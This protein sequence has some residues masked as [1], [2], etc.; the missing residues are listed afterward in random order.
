MQHIRD[1]KLKIIN[2]VIFYYY[3]FFIITKMIKRTQIKQILFS[4]KYNNMDVMLCGRLVTKRYAAKNTI[5]FLMLNDGTCFDDIQVV[6]NKSKIENFDELLSSK[7]GISSSFEIH[8]KVV[9]NERNKQFEIDCE[10]LRVLGY[11]GDDYPI[12]K[13]FHTMEYLRQNNDMRP[14]TKVI[15]SVMKVRNE[16]LYATH[17]YFQNNNFTC[18]STPIITTSDC[19]GAGEMFQVTT[20]PLDDK[21]NMDKCYK[22]GELEYENDFFGE[23]SYLTVSGQLNGEIYAC[24]MG[25]IYTFGPTF[26][27]ENSNTRRHLAEFWMIEPEMAYA[28]INR[29]MLVAEEY[30]K[31]CLN[32]VMENCEKELEYLDTYCSKH[33]DEKEDIPLLEKLNNIISNDFQKVT[34]TE[35]IEILEENNELFSEKVYWGIDLSSEHE[36]WLVEKYFKKPTIVIDYPKEIK[37]FYM[38]ENDDGKTVAA[39]DVLV[40]G[41]GE[42]IGGSQREERLDRLE[43]RLEENDL[44]KETYKF[45]LNLRKYG[46]VVHSGFGLGF[47]RLVLLC[48]GMKNIRDVIPFPR[49]PKH[50]SDI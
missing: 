28:D 27:A 30:V 49:W 39:M 17:K 29:N 48:T 34:Y 35:A 50:G 3:Y 36:R 8:G 37:S 41:I 7:C 26:R 19:E 31:Y 47:E 32:H 12:S 9:I 1:K 5:V 43:K 10:K 40:P 18:V 44:D 20:L 42:L 13:K 24:A 4:E 22:N 23:K 33:L 2:N 16:L 38:R 6:V 45:Y 25:D 14:R 11:C 46:T 21:S 15:Y